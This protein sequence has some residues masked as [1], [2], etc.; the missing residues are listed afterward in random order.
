MV[1]QPV[2]QRDGIAAAGSGT[3]NNGQQFGR[4]QDMCAV[5]HQTLARSFRL[6]GRGGT[7]HELPAVKGLYRL[8]I[9]CQTARRMTAVLDH[10]HP[11]VETL[12]GPVTAPVEYM[13]A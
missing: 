8:D 4:C 7:G 1:D 6:P 3:K 11:H 12:A 9:P 10:A 2:P 5:R 13:P